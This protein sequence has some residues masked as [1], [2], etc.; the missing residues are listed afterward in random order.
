MG[1]HLLQGMLSMIP[2]PETLNPET[3]NSW[4]HGPR[5]KLR[6]AARHTRRRG[7]PKSLLDK[8]TQRGPRIPTIDPRHLKLRM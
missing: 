6:N 1:P 8:A 3:L 4:D 2:K 5:A 7:P